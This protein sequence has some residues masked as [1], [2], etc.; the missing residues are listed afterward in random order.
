MW[1]QMHR[2][3]GKAAINQSSSRMLAGTLGSGVAPPPQKESAGTLGSGV[4]MEGHP[5]FLEG[6]ER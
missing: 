2:V 3:G 6:T 5:F 4:A 1:G